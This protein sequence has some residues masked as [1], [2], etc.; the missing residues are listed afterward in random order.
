MDIVMIYEILKPIFKNEIQLD[1]THGDFGK[2]VHSLWCPD[3]G[4][5]YLSSF[6]ELATWDGSYG[7]AQI[8]LGSIKKAL[9]FSCKDT[10]P[11][12]LP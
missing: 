8:G 4:L 11:I 2:G 1:W 5:R 10:P 12:N 3:K 9:I 7:R 6:S